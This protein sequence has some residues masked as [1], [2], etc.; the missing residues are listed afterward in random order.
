MRTRLL[1]LA[2]GTPLALVLGAP[3]AAHA[4]PQGSGAPPVAVLAL[5]SDDAEEQAEALTSALRSRLRAMRG[6]SL[7]EGDYALEVLSLA[8]KCPPTPDAA[9]EARIGDQVHADRFVWGTL[10]RVRGRHEVVARL[11]LWTRDKEASATE[12]TFTDNLTAPTDDAIKKIADA[13]LQKLLP[14]TT[15]GGVTVRTSAAS[16]PLFVDGQPAGDAREGRAVLDLAPGEHRVEARPADGPV[17]AGT[18]TI[19]AGTSVQLVLAKL[20]APPPNPFVAP[21]PNP[22][23]R[24]RALAPTGDEHGGGTW[25]GTAGWIGVGVGTALGLGGVY[26]ILKVH[27]LQSDDGYDAYRRGFRPGQDVCAEARAG[28]TSPNVAASSPAD[29]VST[30]DS[31]STLHTL[32]FVLLGLGAA[33][34]GAGVYLLAT[35]SSAPPRASAWNVTPSAAPGS[36]RLDLRVSF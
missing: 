34:A 13:A 16:A 4:E 35:D 8:L 1:A 29:V 10:A 3:R 17:E 24:D 32:Q 30:C 6:Y 11:H 19:R 22:F 23:E 18:V 20:A 7:A 2:L 26:A 28:H 15:R 12:V 21:P 33:T 9:C 14:S 25:R 5:S 31:A 36:A 27:S